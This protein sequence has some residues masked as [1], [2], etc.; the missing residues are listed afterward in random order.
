MRWSEEPP[1]RKYAMPSN[2]VLDEPTGALDTKSSEN[3]DDILCDLAHSERRS[4]VVVTHDPAFAP[5]AD[6][7]SRSSTG[8]WCIE[9][10]RGQTVALDA[11]LR[12]R[13]A[14]S[15]SAAFIGRVG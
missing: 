11:R 13:C 5:G 10:P 12:A 15:D 2:T 1:K 4:F 6:R 7:R 8:G 9:E 3:V 14:K